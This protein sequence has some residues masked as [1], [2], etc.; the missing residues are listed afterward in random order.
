MQQLSEASGIDLLARCAQPTSSP[1]FA[2]IAQTRTGE[3]IWDSQR[4]EE[5]TSF[6]Q[7]RAGLTFYYQLYCVSAS[8]SPL[9]DLEW[10]SLLE[11]DESAEGSIVRSRDDHPSQ[12]SLFIEAA[13]MGIIQLR[14]DPRAAR[15]GPKKIPLPGSG[16][17]AAR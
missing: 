12:L 14:I 3:K 5:L 2:R 10:V 7:T 6:L 9:L 16:T 15:V 17:A 4:L 11:R 8:V 1:P 13:G